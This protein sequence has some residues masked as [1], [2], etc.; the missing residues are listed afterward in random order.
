MV[1]LDIL[2]LGL[3]YYI[4]MELC[5]IIITKEVFDNTKFRNKTLRCYNISVLIYGF[6]I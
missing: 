3:V 4:L 2:F 1:I 6:L 5:T